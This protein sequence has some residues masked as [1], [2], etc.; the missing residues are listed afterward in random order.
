M[1]L[2][3]AKLL[4]V[5]LAQL[6]AAPPVTGAAEEAKRQAAAAAAAAAE[7]PRASQISDASV[8]NSF[9]L[10]P[11]GIAQDRR[12]ND[13]SSAPAA[14]AGAPAAA[15]ATATINP[16]AA[17]AA[18]PAIDPILA[19]QA[20]QVE[21]ACKDPLNRL[22]EELELCRRYYETTFQDKPLQRLIFVGGEARQK[23]LCQHIARTLG[24]AA[25]VGDP[26]PRLKRDENDDIECIDRRQQHPAW[27]MA[28]GLS[29]GPAGGN[30]DEGGRMKDEAKAEV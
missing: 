29:M 21:A 25:Q 13:L 7:A 5:K 10:L 24:L 4:R 28:V 30:K 19:K 9:A 26:M 14:A 6:L 2:D 1:K 3:E 20:K 22:V 18:A 15:L 16:P 17:A 23:G 8:E 27:A 11:A 12:R